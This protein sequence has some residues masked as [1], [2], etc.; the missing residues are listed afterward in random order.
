MRSILLAAGALLVLAAGGVG[1]RQWRQANAAPVAGDTTRAPAGTR[2]IVEV[3]N[4]SGVSGHA[5]RASFLLRD[6][7]FD[8]VTWG[9]HPSRVSETVVEDITRKGDAAQRV[10]RVLGGARIADGK[11][12]LQRGI[13]LRIRV[14]ASWKLPPG[15]Y[16]P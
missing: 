12:S 9:N 1:V 14:G 13:D 3:L 15:V 4:A 6:R 2:V 11:D 8:V 7:G 5:R 10:A 16:Y